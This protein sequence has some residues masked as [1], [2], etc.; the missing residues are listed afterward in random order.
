[1]GMNHLFG[2]EFNAGTSQH[3]LTEGEFDAASLYQIL[4]KTFPVKSL[5]SLLSLRSLLVPVSVVLQEIIYAGEL[6][7]QDVEPQT[8]CIKPFQIGLVCADNL[9]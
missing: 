3:L 4:G 5:P 1:M 9:A 8:S 2:P 7:L 6:I